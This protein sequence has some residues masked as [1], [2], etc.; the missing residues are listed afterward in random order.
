MKSER[1]YLKKL[2]QREIGEDE[3]YEK[4]RKFTNKKMV[5]KKPKSIKKDKWNE[6]EY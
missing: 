4:E 1:A 6:K 5:V 3:F 2:A